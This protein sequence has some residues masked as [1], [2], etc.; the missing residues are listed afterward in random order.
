MVCLDVFELDRVHA[1]MEARSSLIKH[2]IAH[3]FENMRLRVIQDNVLNGEA[4]KMGIGTFMARFFNHHHVKYEHKSAAKKGVRKRKLSHRFF[5]H[6][7]ILRH[8][9]VVAYELPLL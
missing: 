8:I 7:K 1:C 6:F 5:G 3:N 9:R 4:R 2:I